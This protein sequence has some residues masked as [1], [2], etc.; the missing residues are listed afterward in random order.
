M[1]IS[2]H[3]GSKIGPIMPATEEA[4]SRVKVDIHHPSMFMQ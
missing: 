3:G 2:P 1:L 4:P